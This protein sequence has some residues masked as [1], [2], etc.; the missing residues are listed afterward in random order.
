MRI[1]ELA[2]RTGATTRALRYYEQR[3]LLTSVRSGNGY[4]DYDPS[5]VTL[6]RNIRTLLAAGLTSDDLRHFDGCLSRDL[7]NEPT[8]E[9]VVE[10]YEQRLSAVEE[11]IAALAELRTRLRH[12]LEELRSPSSDG[13]ARPEFSSQVR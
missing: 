3:G 7:S 6:V 12:Q 1:G 4:R 8:C 13:I 11:R 5:S 2:R 9:G 10:L